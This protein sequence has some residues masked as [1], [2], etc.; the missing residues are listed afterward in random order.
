MDLQRIYAGQNP[1]FP[2]TYLN[3]IGEAIIR[4]EEAYCHW[5]YNN[6]NQ[7]QRIERVFAYELYHQ[8]RQL[9]YWKNNFQ[10]LRFDGEIGKQLNDNIETCGVTLQNFDFG[11]RRFSPDLVLHLSQTDRQEINQKVIVELKSREVGDRELAKTILKLNHYIRILNFQY[12]TLI[13]VNT[14]FDELVEQLSTLFD[15]PTNQEWQERFN[16]VIIMNYKDRNL[17]VKT[18]FKALTE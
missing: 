14:D 12:A 5:A 13:S 3:D 17:T 6:G 15:N 1:P 11:Q 10:N 18:L 7:D 2:L 9:T 4:V 8:F 16:R